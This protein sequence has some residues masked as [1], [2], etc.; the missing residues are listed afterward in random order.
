MV[1][2]LDLDN[3]RAVVEI[4][5]G[6]GVFSGTI[7]DAIHPECRFFGIEIDS[8][9]AQITR[10]HHPDI[11]IH[12][13]SVANVRDLCDREGIEQLDAV[14]CGLPWAAFSAPMQREFMDA[15]MTVLRPGGQFVTFAYQ[16][17]LLVPG[18]RRFRRLLRGYFS[19]VGRSST[20]W[21]N[22][23]PAFV[24]ECRR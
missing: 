4:G 17:G 12:N 9:L 6:T 23:P 1:E 3:A 14:I 7:F 21:R 19:E 24:Y 2:W 5:T 8:Q 18:G 16:P 22:L 10:D 20:V 11:T 15:V 13:D